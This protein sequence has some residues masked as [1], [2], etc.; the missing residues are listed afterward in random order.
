MKLHR[1]RSNQGTEAQKKKKMVKGKLSSGS[2]RKTR[3]RR[4]KRRRW[5]WAQRKNRKKVGA[6]NEQ[7]KKGKVTLG[8]NGKEVVGI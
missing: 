6:N 3:A 5:N 8:G 4:W 1:D 2:M 7:E